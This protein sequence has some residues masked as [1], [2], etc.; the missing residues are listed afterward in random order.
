MAAVRRLPA[1]LW[2]LA[3][4][5]LLWGALDPATILF[6]LVVSVCVVVVSRLPSVSMRL[7]VRP[8]RLLRLLAHLAV[9]L[10]FSATKTGWQ[11][12]RYGP[13]IKAAVVRVP[14]LSEVE[15]IN[16]A[17]ANL[18][19]LLPGQF[20]LQIDREGGALFVYGFPARTAAERERIRS[21]MIT[22]QRLVIRAFGPA[23]EVRALAAPDA[24]PV[25]GEER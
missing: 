19:S 3:V 23:D 8:L 2:L 25:A 24:A 4:W 16:V 7:P 18:C 14:A 20:V 11:A 17:V 15:F 22:L 12:A 6:G 10:V 9:D 13:D 21:D 1:V 5:L